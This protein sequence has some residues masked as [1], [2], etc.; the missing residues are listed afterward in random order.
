MNSIC[1][2]VFLDSVVEGR[3]RRERRG[4]VHLKE[5]RLALGVDED[6]ETQDLKTH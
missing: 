2:Q 5:P 4:L 6:V 1:Y 3:I